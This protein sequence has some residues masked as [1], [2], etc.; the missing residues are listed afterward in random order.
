MSAALEFGPIELFV[1]E[2]DGVGPDEQVLVSLE[3]LDHDGTVRL[4]D[5]VIVARLEDGTTR[6]SELGDLRGRSAGTAG[7][8]AEGLIGDEDIEDVVDGL[9]PGTGVALVALEMRWATALSSA[10][11]AAGGR[12]AH[13]ALIPAPAV[14]ELVAAGVTA[15]D[16]ER[17]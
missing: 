7:L 5:L 2:F 13:V 6:V 4:V 8:A 10:L 3:E 1:V 16:P 17:G 11:A 9:R 12:V 15:A 14:N